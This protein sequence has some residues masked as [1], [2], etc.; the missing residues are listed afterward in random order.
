MSQ[1]EPSGWAIGWALFAAV[2]MI[3]VGCFQVIAGI[4]AIAE[5]DIYVRTPNYI[6]DLDVTQW[7]W[8]HLLLGVVLILAGLGIMTGN[9]LART[10]G[11]FVAA[12][13]RD[14]QLRV[15]PVLPDLVDRDHRH[16]CGGHLGAHRPRPRRRRR[17]ARSTGLSRLAAASAPPPGPP[18]PVVRVGASLAA[19]HSAPIDRP[20]RTQST[21]VPRRG[22]PACKRSSPFGTGR[23]SSLPA[24]PGRSSRESGLDQLYARGHRTDPPGAR[25]AGLRQVDPGRPL[26]RRRCPPRRLGGHRAVDNDPFVLA[27][28]ARA[29]ADGHAAGCCPTPSG[30]PRSSGAGSPAASP[31]GSGALVGPHRSAVRAGA[32]RRAP[33]RLRRSL[34]VIDALAEHLPPVVHPRPVRP[35]APGSSGPSPAVGSARGR[36]RDRGHLALD[37]PET[38]ELLASMGVRSSSSRSP[39]CATASRVGRPGIRLA[40]LVLRAAKASPPGCRPTTS[41]TP[42]TSSTTSGRSGPGS[43]RP[44]DQPFLCE[45]ACLDRF[46]GEMCDQILGRTGSLPQLRHMHREELLLLPLDQRDEW[47]RMH[48]LLARWLSSELQETD[49]DRWREIH[50]R[51]PDGGREHGDI[52]L[53]VRAR[54]HRADLAAGGGAGRRA[55]LHLH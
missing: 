52:D 44:S 3:T 55:R 35:V 22:G 4:A 20:D 41:A 38:D 29:S 47:F 12:L 45:A 49:P 10:V 17:V 14:R 36:R 1:N 40:G 16:R 2:V 11:V 51:R 24:R 15:H 30:T 5:D 8:V 25:P 32:R 33:R 50:R 39:S 18:E 13:E 46:T 7:G 54:H 42:P 28:A 9:V 43:S 6:L 53:A 26:G 19:S 48:P 34:A 23:G 21:A 31:R 27:S 37:A